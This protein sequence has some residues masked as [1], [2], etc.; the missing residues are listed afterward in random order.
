[1]RIFVAGATGVIGRRVVPLLMAAGHRVT[2]VAR[3]P[4]KR[5]A[6]ERVGAASLQV[7]LFAPGAVRGAEDA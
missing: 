6:L 2:A 4:E 3:T 1:M 5:A 7:D